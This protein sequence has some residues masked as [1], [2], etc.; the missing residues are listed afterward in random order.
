MLAEI[1]YRPMWSGMWFSAQGIRHT[2][3]LCDQNI[4]FGNNDL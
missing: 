2:T 4:N 3:E 1:V